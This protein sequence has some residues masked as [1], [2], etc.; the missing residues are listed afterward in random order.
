MRT[1]CDVTKCSTASYGTKKK[2]LPIKQRMDFLHSCGVRFESSVKSMLE[3]TGNVNVH[4]MGRSG[5]VAS[6]YLIAGLKRLLCCDRG[7]VCGRQH[8]NSPG[9]V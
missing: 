6:L 7:C 5:F 2:N 9:R 3:N 8:M 4:V 1:L